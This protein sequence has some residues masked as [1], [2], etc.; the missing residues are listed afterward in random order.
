VSGVSGAAD[1]DTRPT[2]LVEVWT[3]VVCPW[4]YIGKRRLETALAGFDTA[5][6]A[7]RFRSFE[8]DPHHP[9]VVAGS[10]HE[11]LAAK[12]GGTVEA[13][14]MMTDRVTGV[15]ADDALDLRFDLVRPASSFDAHRLVHYAQSVGL[16]GPM[17]ERLHRAHFTEGEVI[18]D[19]VVLARLAGEVGL[20]EGDSGRMLLAGDYGD[21]VREDEDLAAQ[22]G[23]RGVPFFVLDRR[24][25]ISGAQPADVLLD[26]LRQALADRGTAEEG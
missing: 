12:L 17:L 8:L 3:D 19:R 9:P 26:A 2:L 21:A 5:D 13:A 20:D 7:V 18:S 22:L 23:I 16:Q 15:A 6:V 24:Y 11:R 4:C 10:I 1:T 25:G 14:R